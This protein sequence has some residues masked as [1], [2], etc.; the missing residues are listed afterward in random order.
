MP[1]LISL[2]ARRS[3]LDPTS[4]DDVVQLVRVTHADLDAP[5]LLSSDPTERL[6]SDPLSYGTRHQGDDYRYI[7]MGVQLPDQGERASATVTIRIDIVS[8]EM[9][10]L[11]RLT[12][13]PATVDLVVVMRDSPDTVE[14]EMLGLSAAVGA[15]DSNAGAIDLTIKPR[16]VLDEPVQRDRMTPDRLPGLHS[17]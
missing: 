16:P 7:L 1:R 4:P 14:M 2:S 6:S 15:A 10:R 11:I 17:R 9:A 12:R 13:K 3:V 5:V 8:P